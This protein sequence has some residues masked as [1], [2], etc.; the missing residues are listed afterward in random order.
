M[1]YTITEQCIECGR[2]LSSCPTQAIHK[3]QL[4]YWIDGDRCNNCEGA[5]SVPQCWAVCPTNEGCIPVKSDLIRMDTKPSTA[6]YWDRWF[7]TYDRLVL[8]LKDS[9]SPDY[10]KTWFYSYSSIVS[11][12][13]SQS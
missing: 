5:Y 12:L 13:Q 8:R 9:Q 11:Q 2:C 1:P 4:N 10:W 3:D 7:K 6:D